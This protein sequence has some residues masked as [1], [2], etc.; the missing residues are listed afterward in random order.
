MKVALISCSKSKRS[1]KCKALELYSPSKLFSLS[2][3]YA[4]TFADKIY[5][6]SAKYGLVEE[7]EIIEPYE[8]SLNDS[9]KDY[10]E[11]WANSVLFKLSKVC[12]LERDE[13]FIL[14]GKN[15]YENLISD[16]KHYELPLGKL[17]YG[18]RIEYL[19]SLLNNSEI[20]NSK[21]I[22]NSNCYDI[23]KF[24]NSLKRYNYNTIDEIP[25]ENGIYIFF[26]NGEIYKDLDRIVRVGTHR[27]DNRLKNR[28]RDHYKPNK[29]GSIFRKNIGRA[30]LNYKHDSY[31]KVWE[32]NYSNENN[33][34]KYLD[35]RDL[36][37][38]EEIESRITSYLKN[39]FSF[40]CIEV[41]NA[42][43]R[44]RLEEGIIATLNMD[45]DFC[46]SEKWSGRFSPEY[47]I[48]NSGLWLKQGLD[49]TPLTNEEINIM[50]NSLY[51]K[52]NKKIA[53]DNEELV[54]NGNAF[55]L[56]T[57]FRRRNIFT[58]VI[59]TV[60]SLQNMLLKLEDNNWE[61][62]KLKQ[63]EKR[64]YKAYKIDR[65]IVDLKTSNKE[66]WPS[67]IKNNIL[68]LHGEEIG[69]SCLDIYFVAYVAEKYGTGLDRLF[70]FVREKKITDKRNSANAIYQVGKGD[71]IYLGLL[72]KDGK[73]LN[74]DFF[75]EWILQ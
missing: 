73:V 15:Y 43:D 34:E 52:D 2:Y 53:N 10:N 1:Y 51:K 56:P 9:D 61:F 13:F 49:A 35:R 46:P 19:G 60:C 21:F 65:I 41:K 74:W 40:T 69:A 38:E 33:K 68:K 6:L 4:K 42:A 72:N 12:D 26:E 58:K 32:I 17:R 24:F 8:K 3:Q 7:N 44:I 57:V 55:N 23:H 70:D 67:I 22:E 27:S 20:N 30:I 16:L 28:L 63:W 5:I 45:K 31:S 50:L 36:K 14:A 18:E 29:D 59:P 48:R 25:F 39:K 54:C 62:E 11:L 47:E 75:N 66:M 71:G 64:S 37:K